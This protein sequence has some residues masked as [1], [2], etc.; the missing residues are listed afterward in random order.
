MKKYMTKKIVIIGM[1]A[2]LASFL[3]YGVVSDKAKFS[4]VGYN[5]KMDFS[6]EEVPTFMADRKSVV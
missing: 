2:V 3:I 4:P 1:V 6:G 5:L